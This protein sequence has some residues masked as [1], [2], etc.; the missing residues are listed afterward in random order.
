[1]TYHKLNVSKFSNFGFAEAEAWPILP[2]PNV[3][4]INISVWGVDASAKFL[5]ELGFIVDYGYDYYLQ[6]WTTFKFSNLSTLEIRL[7]LYEDEKGS[8]FLKKGN[9]NLKLEKQFIYKD[10]QSSLDHTRYYISCVMNWPFGFCEIE[11]DGSNE[12]EIDVSDVTLVTLNDY[13]KDVNKYKHN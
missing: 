11:L 10:Q 4:T 12:F 7:S 1:M 3:D 8:R 6:G 2:H 5:E 13:I 9:N